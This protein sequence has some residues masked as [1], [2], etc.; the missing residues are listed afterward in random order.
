MQR[1]LPAPVTAYPD[2]WFRNKQHGRI[3]EASTTLARF[4]ALSCSLALAED[5]YYHVPLASL[6]LSEG[7]LPASFEWTRLG[8]GDGRGAAALRRAGRRWEKHSWAAKP[9][10]LG[11]LWSRTFQNMFLAIRA[12]KGSPLTGRLFVP[13]ADLSGMV[14]LKFKLDAASEKPDS[15][16]RVSS[17]PRRATIVACARRTSRAAPGSAIRRP[18]PPRP[19]A[20]RRPLG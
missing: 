12:P 9:F 19:A 14:A 6:T 18:R 4:L 20:P 1:T 5:A 16:H 11:A 3:Y 13:K 8:L 7:K 15:K 2:C 17:R 10:S